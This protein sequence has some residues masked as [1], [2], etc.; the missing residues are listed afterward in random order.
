MI[1]LDTED[2]REREKEE[3]MRERDNGRKERDRERERIHSR[4]AAEGNVT[5]PN[6]HL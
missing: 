4:E 5:T 2:G 6:R 1:I 3:A